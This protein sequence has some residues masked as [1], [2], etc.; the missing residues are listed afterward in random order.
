M[1]LKRK[2]TN[3]SETNSSAAGDLNPREERYKARRVSTNALV[4]TAASLQLGTAVA[5]EDVAV[6]NT[7]STTAKCVESMK[8]IGKILQDLNASASTSTSLQVDT[9]VVTE[10]ISTANASSNEN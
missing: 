4:S 2:P 10:K 9:L 3:I 6:A 8:S 5:T 1:S 7:A